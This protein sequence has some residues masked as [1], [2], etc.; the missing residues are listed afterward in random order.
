MSLHKRVIAAAAEKAQKAK[1][2][3]LAVLSS[4][5]LEDPAAQ[6][7][8]FLLQQLLGWART[9]GQLAL[10]PLQWEAEE[11]AEAMMESMMSVGLVAKKKDGDEGTEKEPPIVGDAEANEIKTGTKQDGRLESYALS[12]VLRTQD[13]EEVQDRAL[14]E[15][16]FLFAAYRVECWCGA[17]HQP[18]HSFFQLTPRR[19]WEPIEL[20]RKLSLTSILALIA[21]GSAGQV[22]VGM[23]ISFFC[24]LPY[25]ASLARSVTDNS[26]ALCANLRLKPFAEG[27]E[28]HIHLNIT[29]RR[30]RC[31]AP[32]DGVNFIN[33]V[34]HLNLVQTPLSLIQTCGRSLMTPRTVLCSLCG[35]AFEGQSRWRW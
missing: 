3:L 18:L 8:A 33:M 7:R 2:A 15:V 17:A 34:A 29:A 32:T 11:G 12:P 26:P 27:A 30:S 19:Y 6:R 28:P 13:I 22:V 16:G 1:D 10:A 5:P 24:A 21:P 20:L 14:R 31:A 23:L 25:L 4:P 35:A 9:C